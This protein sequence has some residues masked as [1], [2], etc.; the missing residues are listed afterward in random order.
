M[1]LLDR[2]VVREILGYFVFG[3]TA[4]T[5]VILAADA[6]L[7]AA[8]YLMDERAN[9]WLVARFIMASLP[10]PL[11]WS[12]PIAALLSCLMAFGRLSGDSEIVAMKAGG[13]SLY[14]IAAPGLVLM[15]VLACTD[16][17]LTDRIVPQANYDSHTVILR[18]LTRQEDDSIAIKDFNLKDTFAD[19]TERMV[20]ARGFNVEKG[21]L[22]GLSI[23][24]FRKEHRVRY[25]RADYA[26]FT[27]SGWVMHHV[28][29]EDY[30]E[31]GE[32]ASATASDSMLLPQVDSP[33]KLRDRPRGKDEMTRPMLLTKVRIEL[34]F[35][36]GKVT[37][38]VNSYLVE[39][40]R[41]LALP[42]SCLV[43]G[44][45]GIP[46]A[47]Q[48]QRASKS[49][50]PGLCVLFIFVYYVL[51]SLCNTLGENGVLSPLVASWLPNGVFGGVGAWLLIKAGRV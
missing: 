12:F 18:Q 48:P 15:L 3:V 49:I 32:V 17:Y 20:V 40:H 4:F 25:V 16:W 42:F 41:R 27:E 36:E 30:D 34:A 23:M 7:R 28:K 44:L 50:G 6:L 5:L 14:R 37:R 8:R 9:V 38:K 47:L 26:E 24:F 43:F 10:A 19:G 35:H 21:M 22:D 11:A 45:F 2:Y 13:I 31:R 33:Q 29:T 51:M 46:L 1:K 39:Y